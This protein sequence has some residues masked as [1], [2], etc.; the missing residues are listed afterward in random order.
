MILYQLTT[1]SKSPT[2]TPDFKTLDS[3]ESFQLFL[4]LGDKNG[5]SAI[6]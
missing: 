1:K 3:I 5:L 4:P 6:V 2:M